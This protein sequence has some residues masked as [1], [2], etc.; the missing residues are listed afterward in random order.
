[1]IYPTFELSCRLILGGLLD[2]VVWST[3]LLKLAA[4]RKLGGIEKVVWSTQLLKL[5]ARQKV[6]WN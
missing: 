1:M 4:D 6:G 3:Q 2:K 5:A